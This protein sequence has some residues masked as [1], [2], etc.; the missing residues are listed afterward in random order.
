MRKLTHHVLSRLQ[1][2]VCCCIV[3]IAALLGGAAQAVEFSP[4][5]NQPLFGVTPAQ[6]AASA[7]TLAPED[8][9]REA[10]GSFGGNQQS[11]V[12][13]EIFLSEVDQAAGTATLIA[14]FVP[15]EG[16]YLYSKSL[17][18]AGLN[19]GPP[20]PFGIRRWPD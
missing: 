20:H 6:T 1:T 8:S 19:G 5:D 2:S 7:E 13:G 4:N 14:R 17:P 15:P 16:Y 3:L 9:P 10:I 12:N 11:G 18:M